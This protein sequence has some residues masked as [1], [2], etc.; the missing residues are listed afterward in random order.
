MLRFSNENNKENLKN[1]E[2]MTNYSMIEF[3]GSL[4]KKE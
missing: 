2:K 1:S 3:C 4:I